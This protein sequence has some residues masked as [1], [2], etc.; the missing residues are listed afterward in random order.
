[1]AGVRW[2][3]RSDTTDNG[4]QVSEIYAIA[5][6]Y[7][8]LV[9]FFGLLFFSLSQIS[10]IAA[11]YHVGFGVGWL[12]L[13]TPAIAW[14]AAIGVFFAFARFSFGFFA[15]FYLFVVAAG[16]FWL[17]AFS[18]LSYQHEQ[19][20]LSA[21][22]SIVLFLIPALMVHGRQI[23]RFELLPRRTPEAILILAIIL[24]AVCA[25]HGFRIVGL[26]D[27]TAYRSTLVH[28]RWLEYLIGNTIGALV[29]F[30]IAWVVIQKRWPIAAALSTVLLLFYPITLT[31]T[32]LFA[33]PFLLFMAALTRYMQPKWGVVLSLLIPLCFGEIEVANALWFGNT[34]F[35]W[36][37]F[38][39][40]NIRLLAIPS[41]SLEHYYAF[42]SSHPLT[43]FCQIG[44]LKAFM[45]C[46]YDAQLGVVLA[47]AYHLGNM[48]ASLLA[49]EGVASVPSTMAPIV[50][51]IC[52]LVLAAGNIC[53]A[54]LPARFVLISGSM[55]AL[56]LLNLP[57]STTILSNGYGTLLALW[58]LTPRK[59][60]CALPADELSQA[61]RAY[62]ATG[63]R[64]AGPPPV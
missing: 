54:G 49:T 16:Y 60:I 15:G 4:A 14:T 55:V 1:M 36:Y 42:F 64:L 12:T 35:G 13:A 20:F 17:N 41:I 30:A 52:G 24:L 37:P 10:Q 8:V 63:D 27:M 26:Y 46:P 11:Y 53:S 51:L 38:S 23:Q 21:A 32:A 18:V 9:V 19:A 7:A 59:F 45:S 3:V 25:L 47:E 56:T 58:L 48:N 5:R 50:A 31:K 39:L 28:P 57:L 62:A 29:P 22:A 33:A 61:S 34:P 6:F 44:F 40:M 43:H 2:S